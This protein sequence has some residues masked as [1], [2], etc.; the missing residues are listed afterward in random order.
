M[1]RRSGEGW[2]GLG[3][4]EV[5]RTSTR[6]T[7]LRGGPG[8]GSRRPI[9]HGS[10]GDARRGGIE[11]HGSRAGADAAAIGVAVLI[12]RFRGRGRFVVGVCMGGVRVGGLRTGYPRRLDRAGVRQ[13]QQLSPDRRG[14]DQEECR[15][16]PASPPQDR[17][18]G[19]EGSPV[20]G[21]VGGTTPAGRRRT[22]R[23]TSTAAAIAGRVM[24]SFTSQRK[25]NTASTAAT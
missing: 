24:S 21:A 2:S 15:N 9:Q 20:P 7:A 25:W 8:P 11:R 1:G 13:W 17:D 12:R 5:V 22:S 14:G 6:F 19:P 16:V 4:E 3:R 18:H 10:R 23:T